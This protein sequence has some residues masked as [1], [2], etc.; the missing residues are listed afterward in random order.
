MPLP[1]PS[2]PVSPIALSPTTTANLIL[3]TVKRGEEDHFT[4][5]TSP[6]KYGSTVI[7]RVY[8]SLG[9]RGEG[10]LEIKESGLQ[11]DKVTVC[12]VR[13]ASPR[14]NLTQNDCSPRLMF[15]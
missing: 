1:V 15:F 14:L 4:T 5:S 11:V 8:E 7:V 10:A 13:P 12:D 3:D 2:H 6:A 9:G